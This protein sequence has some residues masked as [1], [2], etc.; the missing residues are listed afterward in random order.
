MTKLLD[1]MTKPLDHMTLTPLRAAESD[2]AEMLRVPD[3]RKV[4]EGIDEDSQYTVFVSYVEIYNNYAFDLL[5]DT[6]VDS[7]APKYGLFCIL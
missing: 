6:P 2:F 5:E 1:H 7:I 4:T 3:Q